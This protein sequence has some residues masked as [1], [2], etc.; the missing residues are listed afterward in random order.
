MSTILLS[1]EQPSREDILPGATETGLLQDVLVL[2]PLVIKYPEKSNL[3]KKHLF[4]SQLQFVVRH[5]RGSWNEFEAAGHVT[6]TVK[7]RESARL[8]WLS[9]LTQSRIYCPGNR[10]THNEWTF[11]PQLTQLRT[12][13]I[14]MSQSQP[15]LENS[16]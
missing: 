10:N 8:S 4:C 6:T 15:H 5:C 9:P 11:Q 16:S 13:L 3:R 12:S 1:C 14:G 7:S 2:F